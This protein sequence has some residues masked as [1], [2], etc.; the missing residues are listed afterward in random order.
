MEYLSQCVEIQHLNCCKYRSGGKYRHTFKYS[1]IIM[2]VEKQI[3]DSLGGQYMSPLKILWA[4]A[5]IKLKF[6][7]VQAI[8]NNGLKRT[9]CMNN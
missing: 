9:A 2:I 8:Q 5:W 1:L 7:P 6:K 3:T 4:D